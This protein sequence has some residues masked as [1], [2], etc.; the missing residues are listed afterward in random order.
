MTKNRIAPMAVANSTSGLPQQ[1]N[2]VSS[3]N[4]NTA[5]N[6]T[7]DA[8]TRALE[9]LKK[10]GYT[11][12]QQL[13]WLAKKNGEWIC[14]EVKCK[15]LFSP[16]KNYPHWGAGLNKSQLWLRTQL[17]EKLGWRTYLIIYVKGTSKVYGAFIDELERK[18]G[19]Y[20][21]PNGI[22]IYPLS[23]FSRWGNT[24]TKSPTIK[25]KGGKNGG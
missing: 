20:D 11:A 17:L 3:S 8:E 19:F 21:T 24:A 2:I 6:T 13:D 23:S 16:G 22:R 12:I 15:D 9:L 18:G 25:N 4:Y 7:Q 14:L 1:E 10:A 5:V